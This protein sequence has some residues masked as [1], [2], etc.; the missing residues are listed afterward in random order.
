MLAALVASVLV[1]RGYMIAPSST[2]LFEVSACPETNPLARMVAQGQG[3]G[4]RQAHA[5]MGHAV[6]PADDEP[7]TNSSGGDCAF[8]GL[9]AQGL[10]HHV[11]LWNE[12]LRIDASPPVPLRTE[13]AE[14]RLL[15]LRPP[16]RAPPPSV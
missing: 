11:E 9:G 10:A 3:E 7:F 8:A 2:H 13:P 12:P 14:L 6:D 16:L 1:P 4:H 15:R 5:A